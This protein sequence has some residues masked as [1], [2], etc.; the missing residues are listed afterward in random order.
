M[1]N[2]QAAQAMA[3]AALPYWGKPVTAPRL[4]TIRE[5]IVFEAELAEIGR[6]ALRLHRP[7]YQS[8]AAI[9]AELDWAGQ[10]AVTGLRVP[11][12]VRTR[13]GAMTVRIGDRRTSVVRWLA[14][15][16]IG[17]AEKRLAGSVETQQ[18][19]MVS[20]GRLIADLHDATDRLCLADTLP[21]PVWDADGFLGDRPLWGPF[22]TNPAFTEDERALIDRARHAARRMIPARD[23]A[24]FGLIHADVLRENVLADQGRLSLIDFDDSGWGYRLYDL[25]TALFQNLEEP[26]LPAIADGL[27]GGYAERRRLP[28]DARALLP[29]FV[30]LRT[31][32][33][34]GWIATRAAENDPWQQLYADRALRMARHVLGGDAPWD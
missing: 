25:A 24:D 2:A 3:M 8:K 1:T 28:A 14:G 26:G 22:W 7:G 29:L 20:V 33:S 32:A 17:S 12:P 18:A 11:L 23:N 34:A 10:L 13:R 27:I 30:M 5:N 9:E 4:V 19:L 16:P 6:V 31:F 21:R 15:E